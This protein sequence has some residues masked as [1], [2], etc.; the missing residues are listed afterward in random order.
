MA[1]ADIQRGD[2][3]EQN[4]SEDLEDL[5]GGVNPDAEQAVIDRQ[6]AQIEKATQQKEK[7]D[8]MKK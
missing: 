6:I 8:A 5:V 2:H 3:V 4:S 1:A 7:E